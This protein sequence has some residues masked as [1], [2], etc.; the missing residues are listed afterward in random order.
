MKIVRIRKNENE[1]YGLVQDEKVA[2]KDDITYGTGVPIPIN[3][4]DFLFDGWLQEIKTNYSKI[5]FDH[6]LSEFEILAPL[7]NPQKIVC[8]HSITL[9]M[10]KNRIFRLQASLLSS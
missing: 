5:S 7:P 9:I 3:V 4:R 10:Q 1:T 8:L 6:D 2:T